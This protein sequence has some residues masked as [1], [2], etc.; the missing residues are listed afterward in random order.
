MYRMK[1]TAGAEHLEQRIVPPTPGGVI[2]LRGHIR[3]ALGNL[4]T[5]IRL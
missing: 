5:P 2:K 3:R 1:V 4:L